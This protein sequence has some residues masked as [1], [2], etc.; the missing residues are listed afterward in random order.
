M[1]VCVVYLLVTK[2]WVDLQ[3]MI[4]TFPCQIHSLFGLE[5]FLPIN[6][7]GLI[8]ILNLEWFWIHIDTDK[9]WDIG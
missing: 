7:L 3:F 9:R 1:A 6:I 8:H 2:S 4:V 5:R